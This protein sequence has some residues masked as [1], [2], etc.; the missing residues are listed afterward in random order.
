MNRTTLFVAVAALAVVGFGHSAAAAVFE[1]GECVG[2]HVDRV[3]QGDYRHGV[4]DKV[5]GDTPDVMSGHGA[6]A[7]P[8][9]RKL[10]AGTSYSVLEVAGGDMLLAATKWSEPYAP[11]TVVGWVRSAR[12]MDLHPRNCA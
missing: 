3:V 2:P 4:R 11:G 8:T 6:S 9:G 5:F 12:F 10:T 7:R 1:A